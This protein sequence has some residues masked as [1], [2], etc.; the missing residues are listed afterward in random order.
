[1][2]YCIKGN[3]KI[4]WKKEKGYFINLAL[5]IK[6]NGKIIK[7]MGKAFSPRYM[8]K[9]MMV[10][11]RME[12]RMERELTRLIFIHIKVSGKII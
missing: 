10:T 8:G 6:A 7:R 1:M 3:G 9:Y 12:T 11:G 4:T 5:Y 2:L